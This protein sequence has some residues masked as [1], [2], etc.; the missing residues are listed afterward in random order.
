MDGLHADFV[1][2]EKG[3]GLTVGGQIVMSCARFVARVDDPNGENFLIC[4]LRAVDKRSSLMIK[5]A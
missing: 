1:K 4:F 3:L 5:R 2:L